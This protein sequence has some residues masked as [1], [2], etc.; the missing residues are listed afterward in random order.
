MNYTK[1]FTVKQQLE[2]GRKLV[3][4]KSRLVIWEME[5]ILKTGPKFT[6]KELERRL[7]EKELG[8]LYPGK[9]IEP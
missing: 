5:R 1:P 3:L 2:E 7:R 8:S 4:A 6:W 9:E